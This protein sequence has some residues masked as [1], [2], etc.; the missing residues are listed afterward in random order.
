MVYSEF[1]TSETLQL[2]GE[3]TFWISRVPSTITL[4]KELENAD[5]KFTESEDQ[6]YSYSEHLVDYADISQKWIVFHSKMMHDREN[7]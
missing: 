3:H 5:L 6:R 7:L 2:L 4:A 1:Y